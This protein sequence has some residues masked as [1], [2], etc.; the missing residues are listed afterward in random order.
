MA[1]IRVSVEEMQAAS[2]RCNQLAEKIAECKQECIALN[3]QLQSAWEG[4]SAAAFD[5]FVQGTATRVLDQCSDMCAQTS[6]AI[7]HTCNQFSE[8][9]GALSQTFKV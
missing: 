1:M 3:N 7:T 8:A 4:Q 5:E 9:D 2:T 6:Q